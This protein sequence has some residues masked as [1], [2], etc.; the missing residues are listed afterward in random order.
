M[1]SSEKEAADGPYGPDNP[2]PPP[3]G[4]PPGHSR[5]DGGAVD[6][7]K[8]KRSKR[9]RPNRE[10]RRRD[11]ARRERERQ[12]RTR[13]RSPSPDRLQD[14]GGRTYR[15]RTPL[16]LEDNGTSNRHGQRFDMIENAQRRR[17]RTPTRQG[18][19]R[20]ATEWPTGAQLPPKQGLRVGS[21]SRTGDSYRPLYDRE[22]QKEF[23]HGSRVDEDTK[24]Q[25]GMGASRMHHP[26]RVPPKDWDV[27]S[28]RESMTGRPHRSNTST[29]NAPPTAYDL[30]G[31][32]YRILR[33]N[34][35]L[36][37]S[38]QFVNGNGKVGPSIYGSEQRHDLGLCFSTFLTRH[39]CEMGLNC[40]W[41]H[42]PL[43]NEERSWI[44]EYGGENGKAFLANMDKWW[45]FP[46]VPVPG[47]SMHGKA[48]L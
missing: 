16:A 11:Y 34:A 14:Q 38:Q 12:S 23:D 13:T 28:T 39:R 25:L 2:P 40:P 29:D 35:N 6:E 26:A 45:G 9:G 19:L 21:R 41:R 46:E 5:Q 10:K 20:A 36:P 33:A 18:E 3:P 32:D 30:R 37:R 44:I 43:S 1:P 27:R 24:E 42:H 4:K 22:Q 48:D 31:Y 47:A 17:S 15:E 7:V 8:E